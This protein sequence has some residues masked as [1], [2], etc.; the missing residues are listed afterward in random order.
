MWPYVIEHPIRI[1]TYGVMMAIGFLTA[2]WLLQ[3]DLARRNIPPKFGENI[4][5]LGIV[6]GVLGAKLAYIFTEAETVSLRDFFS[7]AGLTWHGGLILAAIA[8]IVYFVRKK[9][10]VLVGTDAVAPMLASGYAFGRIG[11]QLAGDGDYGVACGDF[12]DKASC[13]IV[14]G[15]HQGFEVCLAKVRPFF[16]MSYPDGI[17]PTNELVHPT[18]VYE[19]LSNF[20]LFALLW[21]LRKRFKRPGILFS[22]YLIGAGF[23]R[24]FVE[25][26]RQ[27]EGR[28]ERFLG[29]RDAQLVALASVLLGLV[30]VIYAL[31]KRVPEGQEYG[32]LKGY[33]FEAPSQTLKKKP[34]KR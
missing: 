17:V 10:P 13:W 16:C 32:I 6:F 28:P 3:K 27:P 29:L 18:P 34:R 22:I 31:L 24:F 25:F 19:S 11:C 23:L 14:N 2:L 21:A 26:I 1:G 4:I 15:Y 9:I 12:V 8:I 20:L 5:F 30:I 7:G 33:S